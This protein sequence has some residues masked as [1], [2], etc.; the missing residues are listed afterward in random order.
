ML[1]FFIVFT[2]FLISDTKIQ[3]KNET[4]KFFYKFFEK[5]LQLCEFV[6]FL[7]VRDRQNIHLIS[8]INLPPTLF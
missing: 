8:F 1:V 6:L 5:K 7:A 2:L 4:T 3:Q